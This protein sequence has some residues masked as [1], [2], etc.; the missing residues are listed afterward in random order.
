MTE[1]T[2]PVKH[3]D[4]IIIGTGSGNSIP[5]PEFDDKSIA[6]VEKGAFGGTCLNVGCIPT[7]MYVYAADIAQE[8]HEATRLGISA[9]VNN[10]DWP[11]IVSRVFD[12]RIDPIAQ[13]GEAY[14]RGP[15]T[16]NIDVYDMHATFVG[17]KT[18]STGVAGQEQLI[19]GTDIVIATGSRPFIP[20]VIAD[21]GVRYYTN[22]DIMRLPK[23]PE[24]IVIVG[25]GFI[26][27]E[28][29]H[30]FAALGT[31]VTI[32]HR[33][34][35]LLRDADADIS[36]RILELSK[37]RFDVQ[38]NTT[39]SSVAQDSHGHVTVTTNNG[40]NI[41]AEIL[42]VATG[43][44]PNGDQMN[45]D[46]AGI[47]MDGRQIKV[48]KFGHT[49]ADGVWALGDVSSPY[50]LKHVANAEMRA[51][52]HNLANPDNL[53]EMPHKFVPSAVFTNPQIAQVGMTEAQAR[54]ADINIT[55]KIQNYSDVAYGW[56]MEDTTG[57]VKLIAD[58]DSGQLVGAHIIGA[59]A[60]TLI[61]QL[62]T[63]MA[64]GID[65]RE[66]ATKQYWIHP[67]LPEVVEN[68][69]LGLEF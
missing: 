47:E 20:H 62:I 33:S 25:G 52:K 31:K 23:Q 11:S 24:S 14:R 56:A 6:I 65:V 34:D 28:F 67:A 63:I 69:L 15:D 57:F 42:L 32:V 36:A 18:I 13:G 16:P 1:Q 8:I 48:D 39:I 50:Q 59:Q 54:Q 9:S 27:L 7:K 35:V 29:A 64:F 40:E 21:S 10:V 38:L 45:L 51:I 2:T 4:L 41:D 53:Q 22:E 46:A 17:P 60:S 49:S 68:G 58:K 37:T 19:S 30:V 61:Q 5:G 12:K 55:V 43:R 44:T 66:A 3:Y 26:A